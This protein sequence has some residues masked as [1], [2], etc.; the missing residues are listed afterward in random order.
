MNS[1]TRLA[2]RLLEIPGFCDQESEVA[3][4][5]RAALAEFIEWMSQVEPESAEDVKPNGD[6]RHDSSL[7]TNTLSLASQDHVPS[8]TIVACLPTDHSSTILPLTSG[9]P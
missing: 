2:A 3:K 4:E 5:Q 9:H 6:H 8:S 7:S 1:S